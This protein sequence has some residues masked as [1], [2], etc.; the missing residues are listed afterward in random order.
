MASQFPL[1]KHGKGYDRDEVDA[2]LD[3]ARVAY[4]GDD[5]AG[6]DAHSIRMTAF[7]M[8]RGGYSPS[9][10]DAA[11]ERLEDA[12]FARERSR[13]L[14]KGERSTWLAEATETA[15]VILNRLARPKGERFRRVPFLAQGYKRSDVDA[16]A[17]KAT[18]Y[19]TEGKS[20][21]IERVRT[22]TFASER[23]GYDEAQVDVVLDSIVDVMLAV[24]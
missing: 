5:S 13:T 2:F 4:D 9:H 19:F 14:A 11:L 15:Q 22:T 6:I 12:F 7:G 16:F 18:R 10:V 8:K 23:G 24:R 3:R 20:L 17:D 1:V 21:S